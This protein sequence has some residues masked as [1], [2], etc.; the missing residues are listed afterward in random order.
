[1]LSQLLKPDL[2]EVCLP[3]HPNYLMVYFN[4]LST[5]MQVVIYYVT[6]EMQGGKLASVAAWSEDKMTWDFLLA[7]FNLDTWL[8][9][10]TKSLG[11]SY[12]TLKLKINMI[13]M[14]FPVLLF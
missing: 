4:F 2:W 12:P 10:E 7:S 11:I 13:L 14:L 8:E 3:T 5:V 1:M 9:G 6:R